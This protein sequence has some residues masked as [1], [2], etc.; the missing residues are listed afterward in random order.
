M[1]E[2]TGGIEANFCGL[3]LENTVFLVGAS[4]PPPT[5]A[6]PPVVRPEP[7]LC[8]DIGPRGTEGEW[9]VVTRV[10]QMCGSVRPLVS[11]V[12]G[13]R[14]EDSGW[15]AS[16]RVGYDECGESCSRWRTSCDFRADPEG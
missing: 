1:F 9:T 14:A 2:N 10:W 4:H 7:A 11:Q 13:R 3:A 15:D 12:S 8:R 5:R 16:T 6:R